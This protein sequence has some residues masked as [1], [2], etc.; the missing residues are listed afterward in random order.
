MKYATALWQVGAGRLETRSEALAAPGDGDVLVETLY[1]GVSRGTEALVFRGKVP[2]SEWQRM[3]AP[4]QKGDFPFPVQYGYA[5]VGR[6]VGGAASLRDRTVFCL[7][8]H[9]DR[10]VVPAESAVPVPDGIPPKRAT[11]A[12]NMETALNA[13][14]DAGV[15][16]GDRIAVVGGG[17][18]GSLIANL[19][20][21]Y[22]GTDVTLIDPRADVGGIARAFGCGYAAPDANET[23][24]LVGTMDLVFHTSATE[25]GLCLALDLA[26]FE[27]T[28]MEVSWYGDTV[29]P[30]SL[31]G[32]FHS[33]RL[34]LQSTQ[35]GHVSPA[36]RPRWS[37]CD[38]MQTAL[39]LLDDDA[40]D[41][42]IGKEISF[43]QAAER[44][45]DVYA[46]NASGSGVV[47]AYPP[48]LPASGTSNDS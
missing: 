17:M 32:A 3:R 37:H 36:H 42:L 28:V 1:S 34:R 29:L 7:Y 45:P 33:R 30:V 25:A 48:V 38:R 19:C 11:L 2:E 27:A 5:S 22:P 18:V 41:L 39:R 43:T 14:W 47:L 24:A 12:A 21:R 15:S 10:Y 9:Q 8:P 46:P 20:A 6:V 40:L 13:V 31:G 16:A 23:E 26:G 4:F 44:L 35:V